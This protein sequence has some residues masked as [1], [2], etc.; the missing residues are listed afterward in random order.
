MGKKWEKMQLREDPKNLKITRK[1]I[2]FLNMNLKNN[3]AKKWEKM[4]LRGG[5]KNQ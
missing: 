2:I 4:Q 5:K 1:I 3:S